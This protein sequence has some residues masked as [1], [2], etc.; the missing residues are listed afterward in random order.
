MAADAPGLLDALGLDSAHIVGASVGGAIAQTIAIEHPNRIRSLTSTMSTTGDPAVGQPG[1]RS[2]ASAG[3]A[4]TH[5][6]PPAL[7]PEITF[8]IGKLARGRAG[9]GADV[10]NQLGRSRR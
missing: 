1:A 6:A 4:A 3:W 7:W 10:L 8:R 2:P 5:D 9:A